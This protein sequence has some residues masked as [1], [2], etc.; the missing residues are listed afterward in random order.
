MNNC[1][2]IYRGVDSVKIKEK[3]FIQQQM[4]VRKWVVDLWLPQTSK[5]PVI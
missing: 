4:A 1:F 3:A 2:K 5:K